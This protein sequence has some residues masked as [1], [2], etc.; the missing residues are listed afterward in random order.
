M[1]EGVHVF[2]AASI[3]ALRAA[4][5]AAF[6]MVGVGQIFN[7]YLDGRLEDD[8]EVAVDHGPQELGY[9]PLNEPMVDIRATL[10]H[11]R[12]EGVIGPDCETALLGIAKQLFYAQRQYPKLFAVA[13]NQGADAGELDQLQV[14]IRRGKVSLKRNDALAMLGVIRDFVQSDPGPF[15]AAYRFERTEMWETDMALAAKFESFTSS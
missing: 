9:P 12:Q 3:G 1:S 11:A 4:E 14:W 6:G 15:E 8:D 10:M 7:D 13:K 2:G 5:L